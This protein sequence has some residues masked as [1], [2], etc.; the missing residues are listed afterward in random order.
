MS[1]AIA[2]LLVAFSSIVARN[3][4]SQASFLSRLTTSEALA[5]LRSQQFEA[6][7][8]SCPKACACMT[9]RDRSLS[10]TTNTRAS[11]ISNHTR[12]RRVPRSKWWLTD[13]S[14][15]AVSPVQ[16]PNPIR[17]SETRPQ[18]G[19]EPILH[20]L[21]NGRVLAISRY[22]MENGGW[23]SH[24]MDVTDEHQAIERVHFL[25]HHDL[26][27]QLCNRAQFL[28]KMNAALEYLRRGMGAGFCIHMLDLDMFKAVN[29]TLGHGVGDKLLNK[30]A[31]VCAKPRATRTWSR[32]WAA[33]N[34][35]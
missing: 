25:A 35:R 28:E 12:L 34:S 26:L 23:I 2:G 33:M 1:T 15:A 4:R 9:S 21:P 17:R 24:D 18:I 5:Q 6:T 22:A 31:T 3:W 13:A 19:V 30:S 8:A 27:T 20:R 11:T 14:R 7:L 16:T 10:S 32:A 29:D